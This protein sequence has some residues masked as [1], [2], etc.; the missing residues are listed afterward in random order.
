MY[1]TRLGLVMGFKADKKRDIFNQNAYNYY[2][3]NIGKMIDLA[4]KYNI[5]IAFIEPPFDS[6]H[7]TEDLSEF[8]ITYT[9][10]F[11]I[12]TAKRYREGLKQLL[13]NR[14]VELINHPLS[15]DNL[16]QQRLFLDALH[17]TPEGNRIMARSISFQI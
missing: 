14:G 13:Q 6:D 2:L 11:L 7:L 5:K 8:Q 12:E 17:P 10:D 15:L 3:K 1:P 16:H 9:K 4:Q